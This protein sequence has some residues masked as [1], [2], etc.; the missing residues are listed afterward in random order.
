MLVM[1]Q[2]L[3]MSAMFAYIAASP[4]ILQVHYNLSSFAYSLCFGLNGLALVLGSKAL[5]ILEKKR[6]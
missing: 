6:A 2:G 1:I 4:F 3:A 5:Q